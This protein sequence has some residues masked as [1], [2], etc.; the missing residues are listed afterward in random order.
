MSI[1]KNRKYSNKNLSERPIGVFDSGIGGLTVVSQ[2]IR[3]L[4]NEQ[5]IYFG[6][7]GRFPYGIR[8]AEVIKRFSRQN[9]NFLIEQNVKFIVVAC[10]TASAQ[11][12]D[13]IR[14]IYTIPMVG[15][16]EPGAKAAVRYTKNGRIGVIGTEGTIASSSY[17]KAMLRI[18]PKLKVFGLACPLFVSLAENGYIDKKASYLVAE[19]YLEF[20]KKKNIDTLVLGCTH[21]PPLKKVIG[22]VMGKKVHL[23]D[24]ANETASIVKQTLFKMGLINSRKKTRRH[25]FYVSDTPARL[26]KMSKYFVDTTI[27]KVVRID[28]NKY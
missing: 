11:A 13:Y 26:K 9:V 21:Y 14:R 1:Q 27:K 5:V 10:N 23:V 28:I 24:S 15:V 22:K 17:T 8:S 7:T 4:P 20:M 19:D 16:I 2:V 6:D 3:Q 12:L 25:K 18:N